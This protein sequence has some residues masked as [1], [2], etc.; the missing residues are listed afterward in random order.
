[1]MRDVIE[2]A[3][4]RITGVSGGAGTG[5]GFISR[6]GGHFI[7]AMCAAF[8]DLYSNMNPHETGETG[9]SPHQSIYRDVVSTVFDAQAMDI[10]HPELRHIAGCDYIAP[11][12][13]V[14]ADKI[15]FTYPKKI[16]RS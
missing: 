6:R 9:L 12:K 14:P 15:D 10:A 11:D 7:R 13:A 5:A 4:V 3:P 16:R 2:L 8:S 1:M